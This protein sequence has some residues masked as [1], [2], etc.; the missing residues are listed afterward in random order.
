MLE[1]LSFYILQHW[2][3]Q[4]GGSWEIA[5]IVKLENIYDQFESHDNWNGGID[6][7]GVNINIPIDDFVRIKDSHKLKDV[8]KLISGCS[9]SFCY[10]VPTKH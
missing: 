3:Y 7:I 2:R 6:T 1:H 8:E 10:N 9:V 5:K 4:L